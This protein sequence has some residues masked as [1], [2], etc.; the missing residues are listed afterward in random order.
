[1]FARPLHLTSTLS[2]LPRFRIEN[3]KNAVRQPTVNGGI[4]QTAV[5]PKFTFG[6]RI[7]SFSRNCFP[8][9]KFAVLAVNSFI[10]YSTQSQTIPKVSFLQSSCLRTALTPPM[11]HDSANIS[12]K[13][14]LLMQGKGS[15]S[16]AQH[17]L[18]I[19][20]CDRTTTPADKLTTRSD[21]GENGT[22]AVHLLS[23][24][25]RATG[26]PVNIP[27]SP[28]DCNGFFGICA[29]RRDVERWKRSSRPRRPRTDRPNAPGARRRGGQPIALAQ[30]TGRRKGRGGCGTLDSLSLDCQTGCYDGNN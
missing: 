3:Q 30:S 24:R 10:R 5:L 26:T 8:S 25:A 11:R 15:L 7:D 14:R 17:P 18:P 27:Q 19:A 20:P 13:H 16:K 21:S 28:T 29:S 4:W 6:C 12:R 9:L 23:A 1:M 22:D 2:E